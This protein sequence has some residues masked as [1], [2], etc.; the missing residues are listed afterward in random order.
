MRS[1][2]GF[3]GQSRVAEHNHRTGYHTKAVTNRGCRVL[4]G[5][6]DAVFG[7][8]Q[9]VGFQ[10]RFK[11]KAIVPGHRGLP[12]EDSLVMI[13]L[14]DDGAP[15]RSDQLFTTPAAQCLIGPIAVE[16]EAVPVGHHNT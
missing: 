7:D 4:N 16:A 13:R 6:L 9:S 15:V 14:I 8:Q 3:P 11:R 1:G 10:P 12:L 2:R 5:K